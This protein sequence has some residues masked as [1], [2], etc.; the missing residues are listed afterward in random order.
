MMKTKEEWNITSEGKN[1]N[2]IT[3]TCFTARSL[4]L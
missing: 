1:I 2:I 4:S 3:D